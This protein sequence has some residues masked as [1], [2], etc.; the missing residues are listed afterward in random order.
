MLLRAS[1][2]PGGAIASASSASVFHSPHAGHLPRP[3]RR[4][5]AAVLAHERRLDRPWPSRSAALVEIDA[6]EAGP[7]PRQHLVADGAGG[8]PTASM[9]RSGPTRSTQSPRCGAGSVDVG[10]VDGD[11]IHGDA[12][13][14]RRTLAANG[15]RAARRLV[16]GAG[17][18]E[19]AVGVAGRDGGD[20]ARAS[21]RDSS[22]NSRC[23]RRRRRRAPAG[24]ARC[25]RTMGAT[26]V[27]R[28]RA[29]LGRRRARSR[30]ARD[31]N[32]NR[33]PSISP[34]EAARLARAGGSPERRR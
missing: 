15:D 3:A 7:E 13:D 27:G 24:C 14:D 4:D 9:G 25:T 1:P 8:A 34:S 16:G 23:G 10:H 18:A 28:A 22:P 20:A 12:P 5:G 6:V 21:S 11:Q 30:G 26:G 17:V 29:R 2:E 19:H 31:R 33:C 32:E